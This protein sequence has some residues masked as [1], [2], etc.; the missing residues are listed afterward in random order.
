MTL[1]CR[2]GD[3][4][5]RGL[6]VADVLFDPGDEL[7]RVALSHLPDAGPKLVQEVDARVAANRRAKCFERPRSGAP[8]IWTVSSGDR[9]RSQQPEEIRR[10]Q[11]L[12]STVVTR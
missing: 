10:V 3:D 11:R 1:S 4:F 2:S 9:D 6:V 5:P 7:R 12:L 8:P